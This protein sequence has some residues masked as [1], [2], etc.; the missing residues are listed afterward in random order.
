MSPQIDNSITNPS[1]VLSSPTQDPT[2][3]F[4]RVTHNFFNQPLVVVSTINKLISTR[5][6]L[7]L[8]TCTLLI[9]PILL[10]YANANISITWD[11]TRNWGGIVSGTNKNATMEVG[12]RS[13]YP[14][15]YG[16]IRINGSNKRAGWIINRIV[17]DGYSQGPVQNQYTKDNLRHID[18]PNAR[19]RIGYEYSCSGNTCVNFEFN[20]L[21][22]NAVN[23]QIRYRFWAKIE[24]AFFDNDTLNITVIEAESIELEWI[25]NHSNGV[26][27]AGEYNNHRMDG[28]S[29]QYGQIHSQYPIN[30][31][32]VQGVEEPSIGPRVTSVK[33]IDFSAA[34][35]HV[36]GSNLL[37]GTWTIRNTPGSCQYPYC[38]QFI[39]KPSRNQL[40]LLHRNVTAYLELQRIQ[41][42]QVQESNRITINLLAR[43]HTLPEIAIRIHPDSAAGTVEDTGAVVKFEAVSSLPAPS[44]GLEVGVEVA[45][46]ANFLDLEANIPTSVMIAGGQTVGVL[47]VPIVD[48][49]INESNG[50]VTVTLLAD[51]SVPNKYG[52]SNLPTYRSI[53]A[54]VIDDETEPPPEELLPVVRIVQPSQPLSVVEGES[55]NFSL[56]I[57]EQPESPFVVNISGMDAG[58]GHFANIEVVN[59][60]QLNSD[61][62]H[63]FDDNKRLELKLNTNITPAI[64]HGTI[65]ITLR[66]SQYYKVSGNQETLEI[67]VKE[68]TKPTA[69]QISVSAPSSEIDEKGTATFNFQSEPALPEE[70]T[71]S[72]QV[73][74][75]NVSIMWSI[76]RT[77][78]LRDSKSLT[79][80]V[81]ALTNNAEQGSIAIEITT[82]AAQNLIPSGGAV[83]T[84]NKL[85]APDP[86]TNTDQEPVPPEDQPNI[87][88]ASLVANLLLG[89][90]ANSPVA[91]N[92]ENSSS[93]LHPVFSIQATNPVINEGELVEFLIMSSKHTSQ[94]IN[95][96]ITETGNYL[97]DQTPTNVNFKNQRSIVLTLATVDNIL[98]ET[99]GL[100]TAEIT[101]GMGYLIADNQNID[102]VVISD[103]ADRQERKNE[104]T[105]RISEILP[106]I[107]NHVGNETLTTTSQRIQQAQDGTRSPA[108]YNING[109]SGIRQIITTSGEMLNSEP[110]SLRSILG[111]SEFAFDVYSED[112]LANPVLVWGLGELK[113]V[114]ST[115]SNS[116]SSW[117]GDAFTGHLGF[118][119]KLSP[120]TLMGMTTSMVDMDAEYALAQSNEF[121][122]QS[123]NTTFN[124]YLNWTS[125]NNDAQ[126]QTIVGY[127]LG[128]IDIKQP[129]Y[130]Y[131]TLQS[132]SSTISVSGNKR[133]YSSHSL[134]AGGTSTLSLI[135][136]SWMARLQVEEQQDIIDAVNL[137]A[138]HHR[139]AIDASHN[140]N[141]TNGTSI[142][143]SF[144][145]GALYDGKDQD[146][147]Q[148]LELRNG[149]SYSNPIGL[150]LTGYTR[151]ILEQSSQ[152]KLWN[153]YGSL[154]YDYGNDQLGA[155]LSASGNYIQAPD[156]YTDLLNMSILDGAR[157][158]SMDNSVNT[159]LKYGLSMCE[160]VCLITPYAGYDL[161]VDKPLKS[162]LGTRISV[163]SLLNLEYEHIYNP[164]SDNPTHQK[165]QFSSRFNW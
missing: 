122:F 142:L 97:R 17:N 109:A 13:T 72:F 86:D 70:T 48:N 12:Y 110:E 84:V 141:L 37:I 134:L 62:L 139:I 75:T 100:I 108:S 67:T 156:N 56:S 45:E 49:N 87:S 111:N 63:V 26:L 73:Y 137:N 146:A 54:E 116:D 77:I 117:Q 104:I 59:P 124:P 69:H 120:T 28:Y 144:S 127:G 103:I 6:G 57:N 126:L 61:G 18:F 11:T 35:E 119:T 23:G 138:Q 129:N 96:R 1:E 4:K 158:S 53:T 22:L 30:E 118:D 136:E 128:T 88:I 68:S 121:L 76:P 21:S 31:L 50:M 19:F 78:R 125:P 90:S 20:P 51:T 40:D 44:G 92:S 16:V 145:I 112:Y 64:G 152:E 46:S 38:Y 66:P 131:E 25:F 164:S 36:V 107:L 58:T 95:L 153:L 113:A 29:W 34:S 27:Q 47:E 32:K 101:T 94:S 65:I 5:L 41:N 42:D 155:I 163:G 161:T 157:A 105:Y 160:Q 3:E 39:Y 52:L 8:L 99:D 89:R 24:G 93:R 55:V 123:R 81:G 149:I 85:T 114:N 148:G 135:G 102:S 130:K 154:Q 71:I 33:D 151:L 150:E 159:E 162:R 82:E 98:A 106:E 133:L 14:T 79:L 80:R 115:G 132:Y 60:N 10:D 140:I 15:L 91:T 143:P 9:S 165:V 83:I 147:L 74:P 43:S 2:S 7:I